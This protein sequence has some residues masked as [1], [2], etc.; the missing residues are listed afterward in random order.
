MLYILR[1]PGV[2]KPVDGSG[3][4]PLCVLKEA[5]GAHLIGCSIEAFLHYATNLTRTTYATFAAGLVD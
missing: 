3:T 5:I 2:S 4:E 1:Y